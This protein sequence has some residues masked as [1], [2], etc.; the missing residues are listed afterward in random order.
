[1]SSICNVPENFQIPPDY[2][3]PPNFNFLPLTQL[4]HLGKLSE[5][6]ADSEIGRAHV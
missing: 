4:L 6:V 1:M 3:P 2:K 5:N